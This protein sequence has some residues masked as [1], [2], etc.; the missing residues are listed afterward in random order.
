MV[1]VLTIRDPKT[2]ALIAEEQIQPTE[3]RDTAL[4]RI[5]RKSVGPDAP[6]IMVVTKAIWLDDR[7]WAAD[8]A[9]DWSGFGLALL[10]P[11]G[12]PDLEK[13][14]LVLAWIPTGGKTN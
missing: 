8:I 10:G 13:A 11:K 2:G 5:Y 12:D 14:R 4:T 3:N 9:R 7:E 6:E 1:K